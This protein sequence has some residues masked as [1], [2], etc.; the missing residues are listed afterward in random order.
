MARRKNSQSD[1]AA[2][3]G[4]SQA[5]VSRRLSGD[6]DFTSSELA[7]LAKH[8]EVP[9]SAFFDAPALAEGGDAA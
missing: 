8:L 6:V 1:I 7:A 2:L 9:V 4:L 3:L 5:A